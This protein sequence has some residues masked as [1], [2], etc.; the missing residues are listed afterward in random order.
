M[1]PDVVGL[2]TGLAAGKV[3]NAE[4]AKLGDREVGG[5]WRVICLLLSLWRIPGEGMERDVAGA[6]FAVDDL[7]QGF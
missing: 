2:R 6:N 7:E 1:P 4:S 5:G 3:H